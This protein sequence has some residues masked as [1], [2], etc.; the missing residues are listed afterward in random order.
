MSTSS[1]AE[2]CFFITSPSMAYLPTEIL[3]LLAHPM[4]DE[5]IKDPINETQGMMH[6]KYCVC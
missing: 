6:N 4:I 2:G 3:Y 1:S 5:V